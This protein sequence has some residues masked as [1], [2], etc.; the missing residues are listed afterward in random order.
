MAGL[1]QQ[2]LFHENVIHGSPSLRRSR[3]REQIGRLDLRPQLRQRLM[4]FCR[5]RYGEIWEDPARGHRVGV[6][7]AGQPADVERIMADQKASL[8]IAD[9]PYNV[10]VGGASTVTLSKV[11]LES[12]LAF[13]RNWVR[14]VIHAM[15]QDAHLYVWMGADYRDGFQPLPDFLVMMREFRELRARNLIT[16]RNQ[17]GY[18]TQNNWMWI[19]QEL[20]YYVKGNPA[21][22]VGYT[23]IPKILRGYYKEVNGRC[24][25]NLERSKSETIRP[26]NVWVDIQQVFYRMKENVPGCYAQKPLAAIERII[27][28]SSKRQ[29]VVADF[30]AHS[31][32][33][34]IAGERLGRRVYTSDI[35]PLFAEL[36]IRR[37]EHYRDTGK[38][39]WQWHTPFPE[40]G[41]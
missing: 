11:Q 1:H 41:S 2:E 30:F 34:L 12:Y 29:D 4:R 31:G 38:T 37:L 17:R 33:T 19:R 16:V 10:A 24:T 18:G 40:L 6:F 35:D 20:V 7:D 5:L 8:V 22:T 23:Q 3:T 27:E 39:G 26:G 9:P 13:S 28:S 36:T 21:F 25:E 15:Q 32:T 14:N